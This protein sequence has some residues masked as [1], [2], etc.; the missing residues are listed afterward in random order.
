MRK[1]LKRPVPLAPMSPFSSWDNDNEEN[2][3]EDR[4]RSAFG[5]SLDEQS[6]QEVQQEH[7]HKD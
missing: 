5:S 7:W 4:P 1:E 6:D 3:D 2:L